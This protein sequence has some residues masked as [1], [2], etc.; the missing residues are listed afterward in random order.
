MHSPAAAA[1][2]RV[3]LVTNGLTRGGAE[4]QLVHLA[5]ALRARGDEVGLLSILPTE[6]FGDTIAALGIPVAHLRV[7]RPFQGPSAI[8]A[9]AQV[10]R[11]WQPDAVISFVYQANVLG[12]VA[13]RLA[14]V[15]VVISSIRNEYFGGRGRELVLRAT[16]RL[17]AVT[18]TN[19][20]AVA[21][22]V[23]ERGIV[24]ADRM[25]VVPNGID[26]APYI[27]AGADRA[28]AR[29]ELG[30]TDE[31]FVW[32]AAGRLE[33]QKDYPT[34]LAALAR[35]APENPRHVVLIAGQGQLRTELEAAAGDLGVAGRVRFLGVRSDVPQ[36]MAAADA[37]VLASRHEGLPNVV[38]E[39][40]AAAR[41]VVATEVGGTPELV[42]SAV[43]GLLVAPADPPALAA[44]MTRIMALP[45]RERQAMGA[46]GRAVITEQ[47]SLSSVARQW[48]D[49]LDGC[50]GRSRRPAPARAP[51]SA[52]VPGAVG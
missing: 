9:G 21:T 39:A 45:D 19:C 12:R 29:R 16:D 23:V 37:V 30:L 46:T 17:S 4:T 24:P 2:R 32:L 5:A 3:A 41:P 8:F 22:S 44:A 28:S 25:V 49:V 7:R 43:S 13:G 14:G 11:A 31:C 15:P 48:L 36:L 18:T 33:A 27:R 20:A 47:Y 52:A 1:P 10:L 51:L 50:L 34:L 6:A 42:R 40:M 35:C 38:M 26:P